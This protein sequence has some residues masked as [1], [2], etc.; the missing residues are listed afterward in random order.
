MDKEVKEQIK[1]NAKNLID[2][3]DYDMDSSDAVDG[4]S[5]RR[6]SRRI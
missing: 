2:L 5:S 3:D 4:I 1:H 6:A